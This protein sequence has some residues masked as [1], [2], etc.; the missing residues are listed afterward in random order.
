M[1]Y[2]DWTII[3]ESQ[4]LNGRT[5]YLCRC[6]CGIEKMV[7][8]NNLKRGVSKNCGCGRRAKVGSINRSHGAGAARINGSRAASVW[9]DMHKRCRN[10]RNK[11]YGGRGIRVSLDWSGASGFQNF[12]RDMG[13]PPIGA[14]LE[15]VDNSGNYSRF[16]CRW[17]FPIDQMNNTRRNVYGWF[18][19]QRMTAA[20]IGRAVGKDRSVVARQ[21]KRGMYGQIKT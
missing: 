1:R 19:G 5:A 10:K 21:I 13:E 4:T 16:N 14:S 20:Q 3:S 2:A 12:L 9:L 11:H 15:R 17:G 18:G 6:K 8:E 7:L